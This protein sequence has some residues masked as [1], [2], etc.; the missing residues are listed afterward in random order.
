MARCAYIA[1]SFTGLGFAPPR[2]QK[3]AHHAASAQT[4]DSTI[5]LLRGKKRRHGKYQTQVGIAKDKDVNLRSRTTDTVGYKTRH[6]FERDTATR[7]CLSSTNW[8]RNE[9]N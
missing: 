1:V 9:F 4:A 5:H 3:D 7:L 2:V 6:E 8:S